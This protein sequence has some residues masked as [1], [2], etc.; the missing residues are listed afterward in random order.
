VYDFFLISF[1]L[2][3]LC[4]VTDSKHMTN[5]LKA[6]IDTTPY[7]TYCTGVGEN[8]FWD[9]LLKGLRKPFGH[10]PIATA[11]LFDIITTIL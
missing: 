3:M 11:K 5:R 4:F 9:A 6:L 2:K 7:L 1:F 8:V 10:P